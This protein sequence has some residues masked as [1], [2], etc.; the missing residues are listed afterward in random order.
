MQNN[1]QWQCLFFDQL[2][3]KQLYAIL[4]ARH[5]VF[6]IEQNCIYQDKDYI[7]HH[8]HHLVAWTPEGKV[9]AYSRIVPPGKIFAEASIGRVLTTALG[10]GMGLGKQLIS[11]SIQE[12]TKLYPNDGLKIA[13][14]QY[15]EKFYQ[16][17][18][19]ETVSA[20]YLEDGIPHVEMVLKSQQ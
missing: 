7:D 16:S 4:E 1:I 17:F 13:A 11:K 10:R 12:T 19:F 18:G 6:I 20:M 5:E 2:S 14:Q 9:A 3:T 15:L 8:C